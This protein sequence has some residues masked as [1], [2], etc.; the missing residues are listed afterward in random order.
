MTQGLSYAGQPTFTSDFLSGLDSRFTYAR[1]GNA[2]M[3]DSTGTMFWAPANTVIQSV[4]NSVWNTTHAATITEN[5]GLAP[6]GTNSLSLITESA[7]TALHYTGNSTGVGQ[8]VGQ[9]YTV[10][11]YFKKGTASYISLGMNSSLFGSNAWANFTF[12]EAGVPTLSAQGSAVIGT[13]KIQTV[14]G[15]PGIYRLSFSAPA[16]T[17]TAGGPLVV[18]FTNNPANYVPSYLGT[19]LTVY[20]WGF[21]IEPTSYN[22]PQPYIPTTTAAYYGARQNYDPATLALEGLLSEGQRTNFEPESQR[23]STWSNNSAVSVTDNFYASPDGKQN[24]SQ[25]ETALSVRGRFKDATGLTAATFYAVSGYVKSFSGSPRIRVGPETTEDTTGNGSIDINTTTGAVQTFGSKTYGRYSVLLPNGWTYF[26][27]YVKT[28]AAQT[29][30]RYLAYSI[31]GGAVYSLWGAQVERGTSA[32]SHIP[33]YGAA[34]TRAA[35]VAPY[36]QNPAWFN[37]VEGTFLV[38]AEVPYSAPAT[39]AYFAGFDNGTGNE[40]IANFIETTGKPTGGNANGGTVTV[41]GGALAAITRNTLIRAIRSY[42]NGDN[43]FAA[44]GVLDTDGTLRAAG[45]PT[46]ITHFRI[47][48]GIIAN[49]ELNG[50]IKRVLCWNKKLTEAQH[51]SLTQV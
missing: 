47:G 28:G 6:D 23:I 50:H 38:E 42:K 11:G 9:N 31:D 21:Q 4:P 20:A 2:T 19:G 8:V 41:S 24:A 33:T 34:A 7:T 18:A 49:R 37:P 29:A 43:Q 3:F 25:I 17:T 51:Q 45:V 15:Y 48:G 12:D 13:P 30:L 46:G 39:R 1:A 40:V 27:F 36:I 26:R 22:S 10:S 5:Q 32:T 16:T 35:D 44:N 14:D